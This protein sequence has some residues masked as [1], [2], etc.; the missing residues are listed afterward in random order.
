MKVDGGALVK[1]RVFGPQFWINLGS[2]YAKI[3]EYQAAIDSFAR[4]IDETPQNPDGYLSCAAAYMELEDFE[5]AIS[6]C[7][8]GIQYAQKHK[9]KKLHKLLQEEKSRIEKEYQKSKYGTFSS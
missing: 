8:V 1:K 6:T 2:S 5:E 3:G 7:D 4:A 9:A